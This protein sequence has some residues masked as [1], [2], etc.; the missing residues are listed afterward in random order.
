[1]TIGNNFRERP[2]QIGTKGQ[3]GLEGMVCF[4][5]FF[6][7]KQTNR[8]T[9]RLPVTFGHIEKKVRLILKCVWRIGEALIT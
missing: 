9:D 3:R 5:F 1:M 7:M 4:V 2:F 8:Q 6:P